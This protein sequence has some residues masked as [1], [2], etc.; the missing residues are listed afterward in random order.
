MTRK[1]FETA[2]RRSEKA[3]VVNDV[4]LE[5]DLDG[6]EMTANPPTPGQLVLFLTSGRLGA[7]KQVQALFRFLD[8]VLDPA[9]YRHIEDALT[10]GVE[11]SLLSDIASWMVEEWSGRPTEPASASAPTQKPTGKASKAKASSKAPAKT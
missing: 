2:E 1:S 5:F 10:D 7:G 4:P 8:S 11:L 3:G 6:H 9:D